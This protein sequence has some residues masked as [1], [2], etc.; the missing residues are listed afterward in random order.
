MSAEAV[1]FFV[2]V[3][4]GAISQLKIDTMMPFLRNVGQTPTNVDD[5]WFD[6]T[7]LKRIQIVKTR[8]VFVE[9]CTSSRI[10]P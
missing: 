1:F 10:L 2:C 6:G 9:T 5:S 8:V 4:D 7:Y 3:L